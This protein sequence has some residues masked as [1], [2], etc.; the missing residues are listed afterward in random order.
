MNTYLNCCKDHGVNKDECL[1]S[2]Y[3]DNEVQ[4]LLVSCSWRM[5]PM[6]WMT[7]RGFSHASSLVKEYKHGHDEALKG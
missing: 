4:F 5:I 2:M 6:F 7:I 3:E 1:E